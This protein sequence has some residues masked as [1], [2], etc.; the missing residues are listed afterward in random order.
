MQRGES[1]FRVCSSTSGD[2]T[3]QIA[4]RKK[5][6]GGAEKFSSTEA[7]QKLRRSFDSGGRLIVRDVG[8][9]SIAGTPRPTGWIRPAQP[10]GLRIGPLG[11]IRLGCARVGGGSVTVELAEFMKM[12]IKLLEE[13][14]SGKLTNVWFEENL[15][16][17]TKDESG[18]VC[19]Q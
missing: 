14:R 1:N 2:L 5:A 9:H 15:I 18:I 16:A 4:H 7:A 13:N 11:E 12:V 3:E 6:T 10:P 8:V 19:G 17:E